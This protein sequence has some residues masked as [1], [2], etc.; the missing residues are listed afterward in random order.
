[1][2]V[3]FSKAMGTFL[4]LRG[5]Q[6]I[7][8]NRGKMY[9]NRENRGKFEICGRR[10]K[11]GHQKFLRMKIKK[12]VGKRLNFENFSQSEIVFLE[13]RGNL[14]QLGGKCIMVSGRDGRLWL[15]ITSHIMF[16]NRTISITAPLWNDLYH[17]SSR[18]RWTAPVIPPV[19]LLRSFP[20]GNFPP[21]ISPGSRYVS[22][23]SC[24]VSIRVSVVIRPWSQSTGRWLWE[25]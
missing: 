20:L 10:L 16:S 24:R 25:I 9:W 7:S 15:P 5:K 13:N 2:Q 3:N 12:F 4:K 19:D 11:E 23:G 8:R 1:M 22:W 14:K 6:K 17:L 21:V 18:S